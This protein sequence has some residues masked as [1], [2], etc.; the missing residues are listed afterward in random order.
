MGKLIGT[1]YYLHNEPD[2]VDVFEVSDSDGSDSYTLV[3]VFVLRGNDVVSTAP[4]DYEHYDVMRVNAISIF[5]GN[6]VIEL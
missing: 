2:R 1:H 3:G 6:I 5:K 4:I